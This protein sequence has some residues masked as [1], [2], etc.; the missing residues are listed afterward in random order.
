MTV[1]VPGTISGVVT[2]GVTNEVLPGVL[3]KILPNGETAMTNDNG[4]YTLALQAG[5][6]DL[7]FSQVGYQTVTVTGTAVT[8]GAV[9]TVNAQLFEQPYAPSCA[10]AAVNSEDTQ[11]VITWCVP[12]GPYEML[13]DDGTAENYA[14]WQMP[15]NLNAVKFTPEGYPATVMG[16]KVFVGDGSFPA[17]GSVLGTTF[18]VK[19]F[20]ADANGMPGAMLDST[21]ATVDAL[22]WVSVGGLSAVVS[23]GDFFVA[24]EQGTMS[25]N[26]APIGVDETQPKA[27]KSYSRNVVSG[28]NWVVSPYQDFMMHAIVSSPRSGDDDA[29]AVRTV[30]P[31]KVQGM[32]SQ[33]KPMANSGQTGMRA[34]ITAPEGY[35]NMDAVASYSL[36]RIFLG[37]VTPVAPSA[38]TP[39]LINAALTGTTYT[40]SGSTWAGLAQGWYAYSVM[41]N[42]P[43]GQQS[44]AVYTNNV[45]HKMFADVT[46]NV[47]LVCGFVAAEGAVVTLTGQDYPYDVHTAVAPASGSVVFDNVIKGKYN[48]MISR[49]GYYTL[50]MEVTINANQ[51]VNAVLEDLRYMPRNLSVDCG[52]LVATWDEPLAIALQE[53]FEGGVFPPAGWQATTQGSTGWYAT[54]DGGSSV[55]DI[56]SHT[57]YA[58]AN[59]DEGGSANNGCC[60]YL[61]TPELDLTG[62]PSYVLSFQSWYDGGYGQLA[63]VEMSTDGGAS[64]TP[65]YTCSPA[66][67]W[68]QVDVDLSAYSGASGLSSVWFAFH[69]DDAGEWASAWAVDDI[70]LASGGVPVQGYGVFLDGTLVDET[71]ELTYTFDPNTITY[72]QTYVAG[73]AGKYCSGWSDLDTYTFTSCFLYPPRNLEATANNSTTTGAVILSWDPPL[74]GDYAVTGATTRTETPNASSEYSPMVTQRTGTDNTD[75]VWDVLLTFATTESGK[76]GVVT[77]GSFIYTS[78]YDGGAGGGFQKYDLAG[79]WVEDFTISGCNLVR[80]MAYDGQY[81][82]GSAASATLFKMDFTNKTLVSSISTGASA[83]RHIAYDPELD[84]G[85]GGFW[86]GDWANDYQIKLDGT[87]IQ[88]TPG[89]NL[90]G[91]YGS[92]YDSESV[93]GPFIWY[94]D[95]GGNG[96]DLYQY[97]IAAGAFTG[98]VQDASTIPGTSGFIAGGLD[99]SVSLVPGHAALLGLAQGDLVFEYDMGGAAPPPATNLLGYNL[100]RDNSV[101]AYIEKPETEYWDMNLL[102]GTYCYDVT[103]V[104]DLEPYGFPAGVTGESVKEGTACADVEYGFDLP[105]TEDW[106]TGQF[107]VNLWTVGQNWIMDGQAGN[108]LPSAKF[109]WDPLLSDYSESLESFYLNGNSVQTT[110][111]YKLFVDFDLKLD[112]RTAST[113]EKLLV[114]VWNG[115]TW[116]KVKEYANNGDFNWTKESVDISSAAKNKVFKVRFRAE[117]TLSGDIFYWAVDNIN[118]HPFF[119]LNPPLNL[120]TAVQGTPA[121]DVKLTWSA[122]EGGGTVMT[123]KVDDGT[124]ENGWAI[125]PASEAWLG[126]EFAVTETGVLQSLDLYWM[127]N[128]SAGNDLITADIFDASQTI[129]GSTEPFAP[130]DDAWQTVA[131][132]DVPFSGTFYVML[133]WN[134]FAGNTNY[135]GSDEDG[136]YAADNYGWYYD[137]AAWAHLSDYGYAPNVFTVRAKA[138]VDGDK[139]V[140]TYNASSPIVSGTAGTLQAV[141]AD[142]SANTGNYAQST[143]ETSDA[144][145]GLISYQVERRA[146]A[147]F[148]IGPNT[149][150]QGTWD[151][152]AST[153]ATEYLD[154]NLSNLVTN[155]YEYRVKARYDEGLSIESNI[156]QE[157]ITV[158]LNLNEGNEVSIYPNPA[159]ISVRINLTKEVSSI[160]VYNSLGNLVTEKNTKGETY[161][162]LNTSN[163]AAGA[164][165]V[166]FTTASGETFSRRFVVTK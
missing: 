64:W 33:S 38:G 153:T 133:H 98:F 118:V 142:R 62:A 26:C 8:A 95:Q 83:I 96:L 152:I 114:E 151:S 107:D 78:R 94:F 41:A 17:G 72:G 147:K 93:G 116:M 158:G 11:S 69:A 68:Q 119:I 128:A 132:P 144:S 81:F 2:D 146:Y 65:I 49:P 106:T 19:V 117:G 47:K 7:E 108:L 121:N 92:A 51:T 130:V 159:T 28:G 110:T 48:L 3:V 138:L 37:A 155:C 9:S 148:P 82:Y 70:V 13:Y 85:V 104:Y 24:M 52:T 157:C 57:T 43:N 134:N 74:S 166:K 12:A 125:N 6:Y 53:N 4:E 14:A 18:S 63:F 55:V 60:D 10:S 29:M 120:V 139:S 16:A 80:D 35:D 163:Y 102:P 111:P 129:V 112:D 44:G 50:S 46:V 73:V 56:P 162:M 90:S 164:Y 143:A 1:Y 126:N 30:V 5:S 135:L 89:F 59:D 160:S 15:G 137:G 31:G 75:A 97:D 61:I 150:G 71:A 45:P 156:R 79:N 100:Y 91:C 87:V 136:Q 22:G 99:Y 109:K 127:A 76:T 86:V 141:K 165:S 123:F 32:I 54:T 34:M 113:N 101:V 77:D 40:E 42:Y 66:S 25:P 140:V 20:A 67:G 84:G 88:A 131:L 124:A 122:P 145:E 105:F 115:A 36:S 161:V 39:V 149:A 103:A 154:M 58:V 21:Q 23:S 27:Y